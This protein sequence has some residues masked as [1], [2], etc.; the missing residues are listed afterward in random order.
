MDLFGVGGSGTVAMFTDGI[1]ILMRP[2]PCSQTMSGVGGVGA[3][4]GSG[5]QGVCRCV[6]PS[7]EPSNGF[8]GEGGDSDQRNSVL[9]L[10]QASHLRPRDLRAAQRSVR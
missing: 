8:P 9:A 3:E 7:S 4:V 2:D 6:F 10:P 5:R 1:T